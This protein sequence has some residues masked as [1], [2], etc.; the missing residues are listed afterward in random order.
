MREDAAVH[1]AP[2]HEADAPSFAE[3]QQVQQGR[4]VQEGV[5]PGDQEDVEV[6]LL[7]E[8]GQ[9]RRLVHACADGPDHALLAHP[10]ERRP[11]FADRLLPVVVGIVDQGDVDAPD[12]E[13]FEA[14]LDRATNTV[15]RVVEHEPDRL[16]TGVERVLLATER[17]AIDIG[18]GRDLVGRSD[19][20]ADLRG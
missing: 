11:R 16:R 3:G 4:L 8:A 13:S 17:L 6:A 19:Q 15:R 2:H 14:L 1:H 18:I 5:P 7:G 10:G 9:H 12:A 20:A